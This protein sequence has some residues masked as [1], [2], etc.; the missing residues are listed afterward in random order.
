M[1]VKKLLTLVLAAALMVGCNSNTNSGSGDNG[2]SSVAPSSDNS[3]GGGASGGSSD[4]SGGQQQTATLTSISVSGPT[5]KNYFLGDEDLDLEGLVVTASYDDGTTKVLGASEYQID[6]NVDFTKTGDYTVTV[7]FGGK[8]DSFTVNVSKPVDWSDG[9]KAKMTE[10]LHGYVAPFFFGPDYNYGYLSWRYSTESAYVL[11]TGDANIAEPEEG[12]DSPLKPIADLLVTNGFEITATPVPSAAKP[13][14]HYELRKELDAG[15]AV[16]ARLAL[17]DAAGAFKSAGKFYIELSDPYFYS[18]EETGYE[19]EIQSICHSEVDIPTLPNGRYSR[20]IEGFKYENNSYSSVAECF[21][22]ESLVPVHITNLAADFDYNQFLT[23]MNASEGWSLVSASFATE[24]DVVGLSSD[25][26]MKVL[27]GYQAAKAAV[28]AQGTEGE[29]GYVP[30][31]P[32]EPAEMMVVFFRYK[33]APTMVDYVSEDLGLPAFAFEKESSSEY[34]YYLQAPAA[35]V[36]AAE[37]LDD[38]RDWLAADLVATGDDGAKYRFEQI[39]ADGYPGIYSK[40]TYAFVKGEVDVQVTI[41]AVYSPA[42]GYYLEMMVEPYFG[43]DEETK[44]ICNFLGINPL[45]LSTDK[46]GDSTYMKRISDPDNAYTTPASLVTI[47]AAPLFNDYVAYYNELEY[48]LALEPWS[49]APVALSEEVAYMTFSSD[50]KMVSIYAQLSVDDNDTPDDTSD[51][52]TTKIVLIYFDIYNPQPVSAWVDSLKTG[53]ADAEIN[54]RWDNTNA[55]FFAGGAVTLGEGETTASTVSDL[56]D[57]VLAIDNSMRVLSESSGSYYNEMKLYCANGYVDIQVWDGNYGEKPGEEEYKFQITINLFRN[58]SYDKF[59]NAIGAAADVDLVQDSENNLKYTGVY[60]SSDL[61]D[62][63]YS[64]EVL[65]ARLAT[66]VGPGAGLAAANGLGFAVDQEKSTGFD[67]E[68][69]QYV[70]VL[71]ADDGEV[72]W[73]VTIVLTGDEFDTFDGNFN[74]TVIGTEKADAVE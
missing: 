31:Q 23:A 50:T 11:A 3:S 48:V 10:I 40:G 15:Y 49:Y 72:V 29:D 2:Q 28:P 57:L 5:N 39:D 73:E 25:G 34:S 24:M 54:F 9:L 64:L 4:S 63:E 17:L 37:S 14:Y 41:Y 62:A 22:Y 42:Y 53:L 47:Y 33:A 61:A 45:A 6:E 30:A 55:L 32:A 51:D 8:T 70:L 68:K 74:V 58:P 65:G 26:K 35:V 56:K 59:V 69:H 43:A 7:S 36:Q 16:D 12:Q 20:A 44:E 19:A 1:K 71:T 38:I 60:S 27:I 13:T 52:V 66:V 67:A 21:G 46:D 18:W